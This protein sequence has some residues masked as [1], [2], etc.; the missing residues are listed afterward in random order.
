MS[1]PRESLSRFAG[2]RDRCSHNGKQYSVP[3]GGIIRGCRLA[4]CELENSVLTEGCR[5]EATQRITD[6]LIGPATEILGQE[7]ILP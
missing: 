4:S 5:I 7:N 3:K 1:E 2:R 6:S